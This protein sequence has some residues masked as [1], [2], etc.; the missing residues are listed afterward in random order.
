MARTNAHLKVTEG[1]HVVGPSTAASSFL[2]SRILTAS[3]RLSFLSSFLSFSSSRTPFLPVDW[4]SR[5]SCDNRQRGNRGN[6]SKAPSDVLLRVSS[7]SSRA[8]EVRL[9]P[10][11][12]SVLMEITRKRPEALQKLAAMPEAALLPWKT[13]ECLFIPEADLH[14]PVLLRPLSNYVPYLDTTVGHLFM[15][16]HPGSQSPVFAGSLSSQ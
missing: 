16:L 9:F 4:G 10:K 12:I 1:A 5:R 13:S 8:F 14:E 3:L 7:G 2:R 11:K 6:D 15:G